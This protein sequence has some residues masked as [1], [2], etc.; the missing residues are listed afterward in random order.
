MELTN[1]SRQQTMSSREIAEL[2]DSRHDSVKRTIERCVESK[3]IVQPP[4]VDEHSEDT[5][6]RTRVIQTYKLDKRS[7]LIVV[8]QLSPEFTARI[9]DRWQEL[10]AQQ[11]PKVPQTYAQAL[12]LAAEQAELIEQQQLMLEQQK[13]AVEFV[14]RYVEAESN[15]GIREVAKVLGVKQNMFVSFCLDNEILFREHGTLQPY[16]KWIDAG[17]FVVKTGEKSGFA[18]VQTRFTPKGIA[19]IAKQVTV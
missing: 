12:R 19:W 18:F 10:E 7:S 6:G 4:M 16:A 1:I 14:E 17:Y 3:S 2:V 9:V 15:K 8:A 13:P 5:M 11:A